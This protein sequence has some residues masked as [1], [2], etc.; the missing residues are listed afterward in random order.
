MTRSCLCSF[1]CR[2]ACVVSELSLRTTN[3]W[4]YANILRGNGLRSV[5]CG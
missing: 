1:G 5:V 4:R 3:P 2:S